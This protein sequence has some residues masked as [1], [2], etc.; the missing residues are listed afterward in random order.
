LNSNL[1][2]VLNLQLQSIQ[3]FTVLKSNYADGGPGITIR[4][5]IV[6]HQPLVEYRFAIPLYHSRPYKVIDDMP[7]R[8]ISFV[9]IDCTK[10]LVI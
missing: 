2:K 3:F 8:G 10:V 6:P 7:Q 1:L 9:R 4:T 5:K